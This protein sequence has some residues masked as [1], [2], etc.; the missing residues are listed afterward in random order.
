MNVV[1]AFDFWRFLGPGQIKIPPPKSEGFV[2]V[3]GYF[4]KDTSLGNS[5]DKNRPGPKQQGP[6]CVNKLGEAQRLALFG[7]CDQTRQF[8]GQK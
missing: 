2:C 5:L 7:Q 4:V 6:V 1:S 3:R 8:F